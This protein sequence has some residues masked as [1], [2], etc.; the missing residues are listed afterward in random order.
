[1]ADY[2]AMVEAGEALVELLREHLT[3]EPISNR[4]LITMCSPHESGNNQLTV[5]LFHIEEDMQSNQ[6][7][8]YQYSQNE[9]RARSAQVQLSFLITAHSKAPIHLREADQY[10]ITGAVF[11][12]L[13]DTPVLPPRFLQGSLA[14][15]E[16]E[17]HISVERP[18][19][20]QM[21]KIWNNTSNQYKVS[22]VCKLTGVSID[23]KRSRSIQRV[24]D[25][26]IDINQKERNSNRR[27]TN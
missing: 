23:S 11:Q 8:Y 21:M 16:A 17:L 25:V 12:I 6:A 24:L 5:C 1:M 18:N 20:E 26:E 2:T 27:L 13:K 10:R 15:S 4:E 9:E 19:Y 22:L 3:P 14:A 7:G